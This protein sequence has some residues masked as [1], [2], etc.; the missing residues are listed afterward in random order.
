[1]LRV[2]ALTD[3]LH[4][5]FLLS[6]GD[7]RAPV[8]LAC[9]LVAAGRSSAAAVFTPNICAKPPGTALSDSDETP[10]RSN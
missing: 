2:E 7:G 10:R 6:P 4:K 9:A 1:M 3:Y 8:Q 5:S